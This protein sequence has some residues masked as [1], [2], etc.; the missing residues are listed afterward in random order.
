MRTSAKISICCLL[1]LFLSS[2]RIYA[3]SGIKYGEWEVNTTVQGLPMEVPSQ[4]EHICVDRQHLVPGD[5]QTKHCKLHWQIKGN[6]V[7]WQVACD[8]GGGGQGQVVYS[9][10][11]MQGSSDM[12]MPG[13]HLKLHARV[14][15][16]WIAATC[17]AKAKQLPQAKQSH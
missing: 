4:T 17:S 2:T 7:S 16:K 5:K 10:N 6:T 12:T 3:D 15:G 8:N 14:S 1:L 11:S 13:S 9:G